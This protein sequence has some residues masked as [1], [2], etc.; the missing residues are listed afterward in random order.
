MVALEFDFIKNNPNSIL[1]AHNLSIMASVFGKEK[2]AALFEKFSAK[3]KQSAYSEKIKAFLNLNIPVTPKTGEKYA[4]FTMNDV[5]GKAHKFSEFEGK[6]TLLEFW[7]SWC[8]PCR[9]ANPELINTYNRFKENGFEIVAVSLDAD[10]DDWI[11]AITKDNL[12]W[13]H[14]SDL[15]G[16]NNLAALIY[17]VNSIPDNILIDK[18]GIIIARGVRK[19]E[20]LNALLT[21]IL[22]VPAVQI[23]ERAYGT[24]FK[25]KNAMIW[26]DENGKILSNEEG[27]LM[28]ESNKY[29]PHIDTEKNIIV[30]KK[31]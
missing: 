10:K 4:D 27:Q 22:A 29:I 24:E 15:K 11:N 25:L 31:A 2:S 28:M 14:L 26:Q 13:K 20:K 23:T 21:D 18:N 12:P 9:Q 19:A 7:A 8:V 30:L 16:K 17:A 3:N 5:N 6:V 1:S